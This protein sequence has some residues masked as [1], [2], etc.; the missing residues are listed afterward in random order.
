[1]N[2]RIFQLR[3]VSLLLTLLPFAAAS[4]L[5]SP[6]TIDDAIGIGYGLEITDINGDGKDD[7]ALVDKDNVAW[8]E[9]PTWAKHV[10]SGPLTAKDHVCLAARDIDGDGKAELAVGGQWQPRDTEKSGAVFL[11][12][13]T[14]SSTA[15]WSAQP[16]H[17]E[18]TVHRMLWVK[19]IDQQYF[20]TVLPLH[21]RGNDAGTGAGAGVKFLGYQPTGPAEGHWRTF[22][23][24]DQFHQAHNYDIVSRGKHLPEA[25][26]SASMEG[27]HLLTPEG[28]PWQSLRLS[29]EGAGEVRHGHLPNGKPF[30]AS[31]EPIHGNEVVVNTY[32]SLDSMAKHLDRTVLAH[33]YIQ[34]HALAAAD[35]LGIG[36]DQ[37]IA[38]RRGGHPDDPVGIQLFQPNA[39][40]SA[41]T[42]VADIDSG[43]MACEDLKVGDLNGDGRPEIVACGR[44]TKNVIIYWNTSGAL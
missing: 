44:R 12:K 31:I 38:G 11:L 25:L 39:D 29:G 32:S 42:L 6:Q 14:A 35:F 24:N 13:P 15:P 34:G 21:G 27:V 30:I 40:G 3:F 37:I 4:S 36:S 16:L 19:G 20:L 18:P 5:V 26:L 17:H 1:M 7:I 23:I 22:L 28:M 43:N 10:I 41:W 8:Y 2:S 33:D 9:N